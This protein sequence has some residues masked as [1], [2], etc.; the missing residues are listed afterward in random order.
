[1]DDLLLLQSDPRAFATLAGALQPPYRIRRVPGPRELE[2]SLRRSPPQVCIL[3][4]FNSPVAVSFAFLRRIRRTHPGV[5]LVIASSFSGR[6]TD[7]YHLGRLSVDG[8]LRLEDAPTAMDIR[9]TV[10]RA[11]AASLAHAVTQD[12]GRELPPLG[13]EALRWAIE[14]AHAGTQVSQL[15]AA[16]ASKPRNLHR[17]MSA[18]GLASPRVFLLW[19][20]LV[21]ASHLLDRSHETVEGIALRVGYATGGALTK[22]LKRHVGCSPTT[23]LRTGGLAR[24]LETLRRRG[25]NRTRSKRARWAN[26]GSPQWRVSHTVPRAR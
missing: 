19:G 2:S 21:R 15:A 22:A 5:A 24:T 7:L 14:H 17:E 26:S 1:M 25:L 11:V 18:L 3:D 16:L 10:E 9:G 8:V 12:V 6:E 4:V 23:L 13:Q 20:R